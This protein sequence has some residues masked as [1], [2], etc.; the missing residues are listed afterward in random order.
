MKKE[1]LFF[2]NLYKI[3]ASIIIACF[4]HYKQLFLPFL[5]LEFQ[6]R[7]LI[8]EFLMDSTSNYLVE[9][10]FMMSGFLFVY[11]Y[12]KR[13]ENEEM[14]F[15]YFIDNRIKKFFPLVFITTAVMFVLQILCFKIFGKA[16]YPGDVSLDAFISAIF[17]MGS[18]VLQVRI[19]APTWYIANLL[20]CYIIAFF[21]TKYRQKIGILTYAIPI[22]IGI[23][24]REKGSTAV[25]FDYTSS[26]AYISF[27]M[28]VLCGLIVPFLN[29]FN[30]FIVGGGWNSRSYGIA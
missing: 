11:A 27:F 7:H 28:G 10:F 8:M 5:D 13:I 21:L 25:F 4:L 29:K 20:I 26:R 18:N 1:N 23:L 12:L 6:G 24:I 15:S 2:L 9:F 22:I 14:S 30:L 19:N 3:I 17:L 16:F